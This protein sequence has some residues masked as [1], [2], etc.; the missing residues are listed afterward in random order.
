MRRFATALVLLTACADAGDGFDTTMETE[1]P[2]V[3]V[4]GSLDQA[5]RS[6]HVVLRDLERNWTG[7][8]FE[9]VGSSWVWSGS[10]EI[11][12]A[13]AAEGLIP[14][15][16][17]HMAPG[18]PWQSVD[19]VPVTAPAT[20]GYVR[21][22]LRLTHASLPG[23]GWS[24]T[25]LSN[26]KLEVVPYLRLPQGGR[27]FDHNRNPGDTENY[28]LRNPDLAVWSNATVCTPP[29]GPTRARL[30]FDAN[31]TQRREGVLAP[32]GELTI[33]YDQARLT[34]CR[35][36]RNG[37]ALYGITA[38][39]VFSPGQQRHAVSV[40]D[41]A[42]TIPVP[43]DARS[44]ALY[45]ENTS[46]SGCQAWDSNFGN[47]YVFDAL[48]PPQW[49]GEVRTLITRDTSDP[50]QGGVPAQQG[51]SFDTWAR[52]RAAIAN[53]CFEVY[54]P[55]LTDRDDPDLWQKLDVKLHWRYVGQ[56]AWQ[57]THVNFDRRI[58]NNARYRFGLRDVDP[59]RPYH[60]PEVTPT[61][62]ADG[63]YSQIRF[64]YYLSV[65]GGQLRPAP[66][67]AYA[68]TFTDYVNGT[69]NCP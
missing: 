64:E 47:N 45:F 13:A 63:M 56:Q 33:V 12:E 57:T 15:A 7:F 65:N 4:D 58:G 37:N 43:N 44:V 39:V 60:C 32:G 20:P 55:G 51:F 68:G 9:T 28:V 50:C 54:Q 35:H 19:G 21:Y 10:V 22:M 14:S 24:G 3:G 8:T 23:P 18:G 6:C 61:T 1:A 69:Q 36:L 17:F 52:Q 30:V 16:M 25:S 48:V 5:D 38:H 66:G 26:A 42:A 27:L 34:Q 11:S 53:G 31:F 62:T 2:L 40:R 46:A 49:M 29:A 59:F 41:S 67:G